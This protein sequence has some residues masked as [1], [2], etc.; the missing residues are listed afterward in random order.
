MSS[1][2]KPQHSNAGWEPNE[3]TPVAEVFQEHTLERGLPV[4]FVGPQQVQP[5][6][7][8]FGGLETY[9]IVTGSA[10][11]VAGRDDK[12]KRILLVCDQD[13]Q[14][15]RQASDSHGA[16]IPSRTILTIEHVDPVYALAT[17]TAG[18]LTVITESWAD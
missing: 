14:I 15:A 7:A 6:P 11:Q 9:P 5:M 13:W 12:R 17:S 4:E 1:T 8:R 2:G 3:G 10:V 16:F 18:T